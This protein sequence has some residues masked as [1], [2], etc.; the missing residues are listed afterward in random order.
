M[1]LRLWVLLLLFPSCQQ[2]TDKRECSGVDTLL[3]VEDQNSEGKISMI[4]SDSSEVESVDSFTEIAW[5][6]QIDQVVTKEEFL[7][8]DVKWGEIYDFPSD[9]LP[10][11]NAK[12]FLARAEGNTQIYIIFSEDEANYRVA[13]RFAANEEEMTIPEPCWDA[14]YRFEGLNTLVVSCSVNRSFWRTYFVLKGNAFEYV[15]AD[16]EDWPEVENDVE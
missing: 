5:H 15:E 9:L 16:T 14:F 6:Y 11:N 2:P 4:D 7:R 8:D 3:I 1:K 12:P 13:Y 10:V